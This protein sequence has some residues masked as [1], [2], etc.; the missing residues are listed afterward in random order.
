MPGWIIRKLAILIYVIP[1]PRLSEKSLLKFLTLQYLEGCRNI[2]VASKFSILGGLSPSGSVVWPASGASA[3]SFCHPGHQLAHRPHIH[4]P[5]HVVRKAV[6]GHPALCLEHPAQQ[7]EA[8]ADCPLDGSERM[9]RKAFAVVHLPLVHVELEP[10]DRSPFCHQ[11]RLRGVVSA[12]AVFFPPS[13]FLD[14]TVL[15]EVRPLELGRGAL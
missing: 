5:P 9:F 3:L 10:G 13:D 11:L 4:C 2:V 8:L 6:Q 1:S 14:Q 12:P 15:R 7:E